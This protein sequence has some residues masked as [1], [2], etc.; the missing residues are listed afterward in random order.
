MELEFST[1][2]DRGRRGMGVPINSR[3][4]S[5]FFVR[6]LYY[7]VIE[8]GDVNRGKKGLEAW[9]EMMFEHLSLHSE[10]LVCR[11]F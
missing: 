3:S 4:A 8:L 5:P 10:Q 2:V 1:I 9:V 6:I 7:L 11:G